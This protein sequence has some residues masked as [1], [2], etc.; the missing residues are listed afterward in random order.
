MLVEFEGLEARALPVVCT[1][2]GAG[3]ILGTAHLDAALVRLTDQSGYVR[4]NGSEPGSGP[5]PCAAVRSIEVGGDAADETIDLSGLN[6]ASYSLLLRVFVDGGEGNDHLIGP[7]IAQ[8]WTVLEENGGYATGEAES[9]RP[10]VGFRAIENLTGSAA[11][12][13]FAFVSTGRLSGTLDA[14]LGEDAISFRDS[15]HAVVTELHAVAADG[16][17]GVVPGV[18]GAFRGV[19]RLEGGPARD[20][21]IGM[22]Q[23]AVWDLAVEQLYSAGTRTLLFAGFEELQ[24]G[25]G[26]DRFILRGDDLGLVSVDLDGGSGNDRFEFG[27]MT[28]LTGDLRGGDGEDT[29]DYSGFEQVLCVSLT[30]ADA[31]GYAGHEPGSLGASGRFW[32]IE[33]LIGS[34][35]WT[36]GDELQGLDVAATWKLSTAS[37]YTARGAGVLHFDGFERLLGGV[38]EDRFE[39]WGLVELEIAG[40]AGDDEFRFMADSS[41]VIGSIDGGMGE[42]RISCAGMARGV[43]IDM[44]LKTSSVVTGGFRGIEQAVGGSGDDVLISGFNGILLDGGPGN[45][46]FIVLTRGAGRLIVKDDEG[47]DQLD[48]SRSTSRIELDLDRAGDQGV[49]PGMWLNLQGCIEDYTGGAAADVLRARPLAVERVLRGGDPD[50]NIGDLFTIDAIGHE[51]A[52]VDGQILVAGYAPIRLSGWEEVRFENAL[53]LTQRVDLCIEFEVAS[54]VIAGELLTCVID[55]TN[56]G[57]ATAH[58]IL[59]MGVTGP[60]EGLEGGTFSRVISSLAPG[61]HVRL[62]W[63]LKPRRPGQL[64]LHGFVNPTG[65]E[66]DPDRSRNQVMREVEVRA[67]AVERG[68]EVVSVS[69]QRG[70]GKSRS[71]TI[72]FSEALD[73]ETVLDPRNYILEQLPRRRRSAQSSRPKPI[74][75]SALDYDPATRRVILHSKRRIGLMARLRLT[76]DGPSA[77]GIHDTEGNRLEGRPIILDVPVAR[78]PTL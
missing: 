18:I 50:G 32:G 5:I 54:W 43:M 48:F 77:P 52:R 37:T 4:I 69:R 28:I 36:G 61:E 35:A 40:G 15:T 63:E 44:E 66:I 22:N 26:D 70:R 1:W 24:G 73:P 47:H 46:R 19:E 34:A 72:E 45:D 8:H 56:Q 7:S 31:T 14:G 55:V 27:P 16:F 71:L 6:L 20:R 33:R 30:G 29:L 3:G 57:P 49:A 51:A 75:L 23:A 2:W 11:A 17:A 78:P 41:G 59:V 25:A 67:E 58:A 21:L 38:D 12:D 65:L 76:I 9:A 62:E 60:A 64:R 10:W 42:D 13:S 39:I 53:D 74:P 68:P